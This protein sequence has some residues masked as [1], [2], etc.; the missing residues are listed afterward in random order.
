LHPA[1]RINICGC[2]NPLSNLAKVL[3]EIWEKVLISEEMGF[4]HETKGNIRGRM[5]LGS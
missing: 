5:L 1:T 3:G 2:K 4:L